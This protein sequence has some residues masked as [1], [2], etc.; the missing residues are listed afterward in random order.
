MYGGICSYLMMIALLFT[1]LDT[2]AQNP[3]GN[4][5]SF[6][7]APVGSCNAVTQL[8]PL[9]M[10]GTHNWVVT[11]LAPGS[12]GY[13]S[14]LA[15]PTFFLSGL[16]IGG[17]AQI[18]HTI[19]LNGVT[20]TCTQ[21]MTLA[22]EIVK[23]NENQAYGVPVSVNAGGCTFTFDITF[24][25][26]NGNDVLAIAFGDGNGVTSPNANILVHDYT[27][28]YGLVNVVITYFDAN[29]GN[30]T[31][32]TFPLT[33]ICRCSDPSF[34]YT[35]SSFDV[36]TGV[37]V[38]F[39]DNCSNFTA[40][41]HTWN[42]GDGSPSITGLQGQTILNDPQNSGTYDDPIHCYSFPLP[43]T[44]SVTH[45]VNGI[46]ATT[47]ILTPSNYLPAN[48]FVVGQPN[49]Q[50]DIDVTTL[51]VNVA[52]GA[53]V[54]V[55][56]DL[57]ID[58]NYTFTNNCQLF[59]H[60]GA[61]ITTAFDFANFGTTLNVNASTIQAACPF[62]WRG[63]DILSFANFTM[64]G[65][66][67]RD[68]Q[69]GIEFDD[70]SLITLNN[71][72]FRENYVSVYTSPITQNNNF[73]RNSSLIMNINNVTCTNA[74]LPP[75]VGQIPTPGNFAYAGMELN[76]LVIVFVADNTTVN[77]GN[78]FNTL[79][80]GVILRNVGQ[81]SFAVSAFYNLGTL[82]GQAITSNN[83][84]ACII[85]TGGAC[86]GLNGV[87]L[88]YDNDA[89]TPG[90]LNFTGLIGFP[91]PPFFQT[92]VN[93]R[94]GI[95]FSN[96][97]VN[98]TNTSMAFNANT[99]SAPP[100]TA[101]M[102]DTGIFMR[103][104]QAGQNVNITGNT[105][106]S[107]QRGI[108]LQNVG[109][110]QSLTVNNNTLLGLSTVL[111]TIAPLGISAIDATGSAASVVISNNTITDRR[112][113][114]NVANLNNLTLSDNRINANDFGD[115]GA[116]D[117]NGPFQ[118]G[119]DV[120]NC[121]GTGIVSCNE[122]V[123]NNTNN[124]Y[125]SIGAV[126]PALHIGFRFTT[127]PLTIRCNT[128]DRMRTGYRFAGTAN[129]TNF[130][131][132][133]IGR[134]RRGL[135]IAPT[136]SIGLQEQVVGPN[137]INGNGNI[138]IF[139]EPN[140]PQNTP[141]FL[142]FESVPG[143]S[144]ANILLLGSSL[145][146]ITANRF[147]VNSAATVPSANPLCYFPT[148]VNG[149][150]PT[151][152][153]V[154]PTHQAA[155][156]SPS[157]GTPL[158]CANFAACANFTPLPFTAELSDNKI[159]NG[160]TLAVMFKEEAL[161]IEQQQLYEK[162]ADNPELITQNDTL[163]GF[164]NEAQNSVMGDLHTIKSDIK[165]LPVPAQS[166]DEAAIADLLQQITALNQLVFPDMSLEAL[167]AVAAQRKP[168]LE[169]LQSLQATQ[170]VAFQSQIAARTVATEQVKNDN[171]A[172]ESETFLQEN[173]RVINRICLATVSR[174]IHQLD[175]QQA[176]TVFSIANQCPFKGGT[177]VHRARALYEMYDASVI[178]NDSALCAYVGISY[179]MQPNAEQPQTETVEY[180]HLSP[181]PADQYLLVNCSVVGATLSIKD[182]TGREV[183]PQV[184]V[185]DNSLQYRWEVKT[186]PGG[187]YFVQMTSEGRTPTTQHFVI[188]R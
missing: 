183:L 117:P 74:L 30:V 82:P 148:R 132:N 106:T 57:L 161:W 108:E 25:Q 158:S 44:I 135:W 81:A 64:Q 62:M 27:Q 152:P 176:T 164:Y 9:N 60:P 153:G 155:W 169:S 92:F 55:F 86:I 43:S 163:W 39:K 95:Y 154:W 115:N 67:L 146:R 96:V 65:S 129:N 185:P 48:T 103:G 130:Q 136:G 177:A 104:V 113:G 159:A 50:T 14:S 87:G 89:G 186:L 33:V 119:I 141:A 34:S 168:L 139:P 109:L 21:F 70:W 107:H 31:T 5:A 101:N 162:L 102:F 149:N 187:T 19:T 32:C 88:Y 125:I 45:N 180:L 22:C 41:S 171:E 26:T 76:N 112:L 12:G 111:N 157:A 133:T 3:C 40:T 128:T 59:M 58:H 16:S 122:V 138:W 10:S 93:V 66:I 18:Q 80:N 4:A 63:I 170:A 36:C 175:E 181:N 188:V 56:G 78:N 160:D 53:I 73:L 182:I 121:G 69:Y 6:T 7:F 29:L 47:V 20:S 151:Q 83:S 38:Q 75:Y 8:T 15:N 143:M 17:T 127:S 97:N 165:G 140:N 94:L 51:P 23:C 79:G 61:S 52:S 118:F 126:P 46:A 2:Q 174:G 1:G 105:I 184:V 116:F 147:R 24:Y 77:D 114:I 35:N 13:T 71:N 124:T 72:Q 91:S 156:F 99:P 145:A 134:H 11:A 137:Q 28:S 100:G 131:T 120:V 142:E 172:I 144:N 110:C 178:Y 173:E 42:F 37:C 54:V 150:A 98:I 84:N 166:P 68:A 90:T 49:Q 167:Q 179:L 85:G 123:P